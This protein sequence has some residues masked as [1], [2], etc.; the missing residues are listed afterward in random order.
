MKFINQNFEILYITPNA[1]K[2]IE[3][4][5][6]TC[7]KSYDKITNESAEK[8]IKGLIKR[9]HTAMIE[10]ADMTVKCITDRSV[11][12]ELVRHRIC[13]FAQES[14]RYIKYKNIEYI[15]PPWLS[16]YYL[17][18]WSFDKLANEK[19]PY[20]HELFI[21]SLM[22]CELVYQE[23]IK[24]DWEPEKARKILPNSTATEIVIKTNFREWLHIFDL[25]AKGTT[26]RP[27]PTIQILI[28]GI[29]HA[30]IKHYPGIFE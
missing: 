21:N 27:D 28:T 3:K 9:K 17:G 19:L 18:E 20:D 8:F 22:S 11:S 1:L 16:T 26:G 5:G 14:Q 7:Y 30:A 13:S 29:L 12:H 2:L 15:L 25:R 24:H 6:R 10:F 4:I 23:L